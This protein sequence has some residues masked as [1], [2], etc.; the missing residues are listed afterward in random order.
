MKKKR[1]VLIVAPFPP[2]PG[3]IACYV[4]NIWQSDEV[5]SL[6]DL[7]R[8]DTSR[9]ESLVKF[10]GR[11]ENTWRRF[12]Q[13]LKPRN[14]GFLAAVLFGLIE[15]FFKLLW[16]R[17]SIV[18]VHTS[19]YF[20]FLRSG[21]FLFMARPFPSKKVLHLH[22]AIDLF[23]NR[24]RRARFWRSAIQWSLNQADE[25]IVLSDGL[26]EW[27]RENL[28]K[29][30]SVIWN[31]CEV[32][33]YTIRDRVNLER[34]FPQTKDRIIVLML[35]GLHGYKGAFDLLQVAKNLHE[36]GE[37]DLI[38]ILPGM[39]NMEKAIQF[40]RENGMQDTIILP[41][42][43]DE[44]VKNA[45]LLGADI[46]VLPSYSEGQPIAILEAMAASLPIISTNIGSIPEVIQHG[47]TG[48]LIKPGELNALE[49]Y[50][51]M[52][53]GDQQLRISMGSKA[54][55]KVEVKHSL[56]IQMRELAAFYLHSIS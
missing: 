32:E 41:G 16:F 47:E 39:G 26:Q 11:G 7:Q 12:W 20:S 36:T 29:E 40:V 5:R 4:Q 2:P 51:S 18:H 31:A 9:G 13:F 50:L 52:L 56:T 35:G 37:K 34:I 27:V 1:S 6:F 28:G 55:E 8:V 44:E 10:E 3:G 19:S 14:W 33:K 30:A 46:F 49:A 53:E 17:P 21:I 48:F 45:L 22:N 38:Y 25:M 23:Y 24:Y 42:V 43:V 54:R 15:Y